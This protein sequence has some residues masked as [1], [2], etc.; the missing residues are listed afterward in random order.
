MKHFG[1][2]GRNLGHSY[3]QRYFEELFLR[4]ELKDY[5]YSLHEMESTAC[6]RQWVE[7]EGISGFN[8]TTPF[9]ETIITQLDSLDEV[10]AAI[11]AVNCVSVEKDHLVGHNTDAPAFADT[12]ADIASLLAGREALLLGTGGAARAVAYALRQMG[13]EVVFASR[14]PA[15]SR[16][17]GVVSY[18]DARAVAQRCP[19]VVNCTPVGMYPDTKNT[20]WPWPQDFG[21]HTIAYDLTYNPSPTLF[22]QQANAYGAAIRDG[23]AMLHRQAD[24]SR[25]YFGII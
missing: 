7:E 24:L 11:G 20:P 25:R 13:A 14:N 18:T 5:S 10:A 19:L 2:I 17:S 16:L 22:L 1:L 4:L 3:S 6:V 23:L 12:V 21:R 8:V 15:K 9:K